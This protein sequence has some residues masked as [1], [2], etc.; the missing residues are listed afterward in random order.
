MSD[1]L[2]HVE[3]TTMASPRSGLTENYANLAAAIVG[4]ACKDYED[5]IV[6]LYFQKDQEKRLKLLQMKSETELFF[7]SSWYETLTEIDGNRL[8]QRIREIARQTIRE[9]I[10]KQHQKVLEDMKKGR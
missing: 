9:K 7:Q 10:R 2:L 8:L 5:I 4:Q 6:G 1:G 3:K